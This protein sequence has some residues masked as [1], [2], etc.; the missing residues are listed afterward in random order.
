MTNNINHNIKLE[1]VQMTSDSDPSY[2]TNPVV[3]QPSHIPS[4]PHALYDEVVFVVW[5]L[6]LYIIVKSICLLW[7]TSRGLRT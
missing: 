6:G 2:M 3:Q 1:L 7:A 4:K 5:A